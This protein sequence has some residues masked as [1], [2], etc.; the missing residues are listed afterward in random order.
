MGGGGVVTAGGKDPFVS[1]TM[2]QKTENAR[3][4]DFIGLKSLRLEYLKYHDIL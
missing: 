2:L 3:P 1:C 4:S